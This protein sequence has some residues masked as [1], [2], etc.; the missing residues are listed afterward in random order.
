MTCFLLPGEILWRHISK[1]RRAITLKS[2]IKNA[3]MDIMIHAKFH[4]SRLM[5]TLIFGIWVSEPPLGP[6]ERLKRPGPIALIHCSCSKYTKPIAASAKNPYWVAPNCI[7][8]M[9][10]DASHSTENQW[11]LLNTMWDDLRL[12]LIYELLSKK[13][14]VEYSLKDINRNYYIV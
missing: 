7:D 12:N 1:T 4:L 8:A 6:G 11:I 10:H 3:F 13:N 2:C 14:V 5:L 9:H